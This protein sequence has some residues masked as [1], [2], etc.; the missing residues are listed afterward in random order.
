[1]S[2]LLP[3]NNVN[4]RYGLLTTVIMLPVLGRE[5]KQES[6]L[7]MIGMPSSLLSNS[8]ETA[9]KLIS[10]CYNRRRGAWEEA[11]TIVCT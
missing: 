4:E 2:D 6:Y 8:G 5:R 9:R 11:R 7:P 1:M 10:G 3:P